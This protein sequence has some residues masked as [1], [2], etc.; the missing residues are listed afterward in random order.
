[1]NGERNLLSV[2]AQRI[3][4]DLA[5]L[6]ELSTPDL[7]ALLLNV[8]QEIDRRR[9]PEGVVSDPDHLPT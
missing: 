3:V 7:E 6:P 1:M 5:L 4:A 8:Q 9:R 2:P